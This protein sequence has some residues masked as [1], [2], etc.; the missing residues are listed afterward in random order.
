M[1]QIFHMIENIQRQLILIKIITIIT[2]I[3]TCM[4]NHDY[5]MSTDP[6]HLNDVKPRDIIIVVCIAIGP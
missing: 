6:N 3:G 1:S 4:A 5:Q 2:N